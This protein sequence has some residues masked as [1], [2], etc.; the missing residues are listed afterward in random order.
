M[1]GLLVNVQTVQFQEEGPGEVF[2]AFEPQAEHA[3]LPPLLFS[4]QA[5]HCQD[6]RL[7]V[8]AV[9]AHPSSEPFLAAIVSLLAWHR[10]QKYVPLGREAIEEQTRGQK[11]TF[12]TPL[13]G[14]L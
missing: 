9:V 13:G 12:Y 11:S 5:G 8:S 4:V 1:P 6:G 10:G 7:G 3:R 2:G 14:I